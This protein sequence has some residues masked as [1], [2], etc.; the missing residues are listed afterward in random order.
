MTT[1]EARPNDEVW[2]PD[3]ARRAQRTVNA[4]HTAVGLTIAVGALLAVVMVAAGA[5][6][7]N[8]FTI[9][10]GLVGV[11]FLTWVSTLGM[12]WS[13]DVLALLHSAEV[14]GALIDE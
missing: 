7:G 9:G 13:R 4:L 2:L 3:R 6:V 1:T 5:Y 14:R 10:V 11:P 8:P 12:R